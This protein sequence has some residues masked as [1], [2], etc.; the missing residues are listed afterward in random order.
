MSNEKQSEKQSEKQ[1][2]NNTSDYLFYKWLV[3]NGRPGR[4]GTEPTGE[5]YNDL[6]SV[7]RKLLGR[8]VTVSNDFAPVTGILSAIESD[9]IVISETAGTVVFVPLRA[10]NSVREPI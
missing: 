3:E 7:L 6:K 2:T 1:C 10:I 9:Y 8:T 5:S 4:P